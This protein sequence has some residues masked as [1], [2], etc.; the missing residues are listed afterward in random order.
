MS[1]RMYSHSPGLLVEGEGEEVKGAR[2]GDGKVGDQHDI[3][4][5]TIVD[6]AWAWR[7]RLE[8]RQTGRERERG[9]LVNRQ[10]GRLTGKEAGRQTDRK[11]DK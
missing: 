8:K 4:H 7:R 3:R 5:C 2:E 10:T 11:I 6:D 9:I 1:P